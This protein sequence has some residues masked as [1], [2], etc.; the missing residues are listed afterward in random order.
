MG[1][2]QMGFGMMTTQMAVGALFEV[3]N[4][5]VRA[6]KQDFAPPALLSNTDAFVAL[7][8]VCG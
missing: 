4:A 2:K 6:R 1:K 8:D 5:T 3:C 7:H